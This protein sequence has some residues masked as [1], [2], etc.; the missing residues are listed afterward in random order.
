VGVLGKVVGYGPGCLRSPSRGIGSAWVPGSWATPR[1]RHGQ[2]A[3]LPE[4]TK[5]VKAP[6][7]I[8]RD[9][10]P[11]GLAEDLLLASER[12]HVACIIQK[13]KGSNVTGDRG[14]CNVLAVMATAF[15]R[16]PSKIESIWRSCGTPGCIHPTH[17]VIATKAQR[18]IFTTLVDGQG[19]WRQC[20]KILPSNSKIPRRRPGSCT[21]KPPGFLYR[22]MRSGRSFDC[23]ATRGRRAPGLHAGQEALCTPDQ[24]KSSHPHVG[25]QSGIGSQRPFT[26]SPAFQ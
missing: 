7:C 15:I 1:L 16:A 20:P 9:P 25:C 21:S 19:V 4:P 12:H 8:Y 17:L 3:G 18:A 5:P 2:Q 6:K 13:Q 10:T 26:M 11:P 23:R 14:R 22:Y 24:R